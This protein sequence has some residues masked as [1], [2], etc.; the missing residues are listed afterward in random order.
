MTLLLTD[1]PRLK[2]T[3]KKESTDINHWFDVW[4]VAKGIYKNAEK[5]LVRRKSV[6]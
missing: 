3:L 1:I 5:L 4:H 2:P 6:S